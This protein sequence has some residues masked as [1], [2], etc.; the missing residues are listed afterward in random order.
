MSG[1]TLSFSYWFGL[2]AVSDSKAIRCAALM[3]P[4]SSSG[5]GCEGPPNKVLQE[6]GGRKDGEQER[7]SHVDAKQLHQPNLGGARFIAQKGS[8]IR[9]SIECAGDQ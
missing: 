2:M 6:S 3:P 9:Q 5:S 4:R 1:P 8:H 7:R